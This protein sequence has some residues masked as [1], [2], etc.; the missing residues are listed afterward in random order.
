MSIGIDDVEICNNAIALCG[1]T[2][3]IQALTD[4]DSQSARRCNQF[5][6]TSVKKVLR[7]HDW[8]CAT[9][10]TLLAENS[11]SPD[12][13]YDKSFA[14]PVDCIRAINVYGDDRGYSPYDRW[15]VRKRSVHT[16]LG[17]VYL[18]YVQLPEDYNEL[19]IL[20]SDAIAGELA[21]KLAPTLVK[22]PEIYGMLFQT[23]KRMIAEAKAIDTLENKFVDVNNVV[24]NDGRLN[25]GS[26]FVGAGSASI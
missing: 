10:I 5:F 18:Q 9:N 21:L 12:F 15:E 13:K 25:V 2:D 23:T 8:N 17:Q 14:L 7:K 20:L 24:W 11:E 16:D 22:D 4:P 3:F 1:S 26:G 6:G 19:D